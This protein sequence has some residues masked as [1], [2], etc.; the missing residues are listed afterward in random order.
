MENELMVLEKEA[1][2]VD[3]QAQGLV[4]KSQAQYDAANDFLKAVKGLQQKVKDAFGPIIQKAY[5]AHKE[6]KAQETKQL[7]PLL[8]AESLVKNKMLTFWQEQERIRREEEARLQ[9]IADKKRKEA[10]AKAEAARAAGN[11]AKAEKYEEKAA[12]VVAP[13]LAPMFDKGTVSVKKLYRA[14]VYDLMALIK[15]IAA[16]QAPISLV[17]ANMVSL[18][19]QARALKETMAYPGVRAVA[20][21]N[22]STRR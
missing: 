19:A 12:A 10:E 20:E 5:A 17:E 22:I 14:E 8:K 6:A 7:D 18:N 9:A 11:E 13:T 3:V 4:V 15:A 1:Q 16:G 2:E 21:D